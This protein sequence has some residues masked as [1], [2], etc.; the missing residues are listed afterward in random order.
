MI[1]FTYNFQSGCIFFDMFA[2]SYDG[3]QINY[4]CDRLSTRVTFRPLS[5]LIN[6]DNDLN[7]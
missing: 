7:L 6:H 1:V 5:S 3:M 4:S 2:A